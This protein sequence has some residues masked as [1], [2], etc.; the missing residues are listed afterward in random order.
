MNL[1]S[2]VGSQFVDV[3][4]SDAWKGT[5]FLDQA[6]DEIDKGLIDLLLFWSAFDGFP[7]DFELDLEFQQGMDFFFLL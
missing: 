5:K 3:R 6:I 2:V 4:F 7:F 1:H